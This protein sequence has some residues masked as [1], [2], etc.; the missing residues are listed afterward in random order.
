VVGRPDHV[1][2]VL[3]DDD[4]VASLYQAMQD[5]QEL[6]DVGEV[7]ARR[8]LVEDVECLAGRPFS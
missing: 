7:E 8:R 4:G 3:D 2:I 1:E 6:L 5:A